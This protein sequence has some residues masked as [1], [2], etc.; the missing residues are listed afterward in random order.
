MQLL[1]QEP[2]FSYFFSTTDPNT[3]FEVERYEGTQEVVTDSHGKCTRYDNADHRR[4][5]LTFNH[6]HLVECGELDFWEARAAHCT[7]EALSVVQHRIEWL[8]ELAAVGM[9][10]AA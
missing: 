10:A 8:Q 6:G 7:G 4:Q 1:N 3:A 2:E 5:R 9:P